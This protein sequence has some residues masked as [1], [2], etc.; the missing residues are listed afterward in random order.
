MVFSFHSVPFVAGNGTSW[1]EKNHFI[2]LTPVSINKSSILKVRSFA[3]FPDHKEIS[4]SI[5]TE[6]GSLLRKFSDDPK[7]M[8]KDSYSFLIYINIKFGPLNF[9]KSVLNLAMNQRICK[10]QMKYNCN[11]ADLADLKAF[12][13]I[14]HRMM[15]GWRLFSMEIWYHSR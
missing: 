4:R 13:T 14:G 6:F 1:E 9:I 15:S 11:Q 3:S 8:Q 5:H 2:F 7:I 10:F 12:F